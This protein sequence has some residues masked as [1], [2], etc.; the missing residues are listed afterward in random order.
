MSLAKDGLQTE[1]PLPQ[2]KMPLIGQ[3]LPTGSC[4]IPDCGTAM[5]YR[6]GFAKITVMIS[7]KCSSLFS[8]RRSGWCLG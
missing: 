8:F 2:G 6:R 4:A 5:V 3:S 7:R 1:F